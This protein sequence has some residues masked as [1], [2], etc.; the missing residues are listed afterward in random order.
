MH[1]GPEDFKRTVTQCEE[2]MESH[3]RDEAVCARHASSHFGNKSCFVH[4][5]PKL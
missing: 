1:D 3:G 5:A 4:R 2:V